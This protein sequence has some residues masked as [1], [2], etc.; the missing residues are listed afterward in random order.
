MLSRRVRSHGRHGKARTPHARRGAAYLLVMATATIASAVALGAIAIAQSGQRAAV[1]A[2]DAERAAIGAMSALEMTTAGINA[3]RDWRTLADAT[4]GVRSIDLGEGVVGSVMILDELDGDLLDSAA[5]NVRVYAQIKAGTAKR[6]LSV[7]LERER[8]AGLDLLRCGLHSYGDVRINGPVQGGPISSA[9]TITNAGSVLGSVECE[10]ITGGGTVSGTTTTGAVS[11]M[12]P[13]SD[14]F[15]RLSS[16]SMTIPVSGSSPTIERM[17]LASS[18]AV[19]GSSASWAYRITLT[20]GQTLTIRQIRIAATLLID[21]PAGAVLQIMGPILWTPAS[22][23]RPA[24]VVQA[25][26]G[27]VVRFTGSTDSLSESAA[28]AN[29]NPPL[30]AYAGST[31]MDTTDVYPSAFVGVYQINGSRA[32][33]TIEGHCLFYGTVVTDAPVTLEGPVAFQPDLGLLQSPPTGFE[34]TQMRPVR[35]SLRW[36]RADAMP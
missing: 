9:G 34:S 18:I 7:E 1:T 28:A 29:F 13:A 6:T 4:G 21:V 35:G 32:S 26:V 36:E 8:W 14:L 27:A 3:H 15:A 23:D 5:H 10:S 31:D 19:G 30:A 11:K 12:P 22:A 24:L 17:P 33:V 25:G 2:A 20:P 16:S